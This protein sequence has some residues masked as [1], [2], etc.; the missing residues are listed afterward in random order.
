M[1]CNIQYMYNWSNPSASFTHYLNMLYL[2]LFAQP[3]LE[4][5]YPL[6]I[7]ILWERFYELQI[8]NIYNAEKKDT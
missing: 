8:R 3:S 6:G 2:I 5:A 7:Y 1:P 4:F